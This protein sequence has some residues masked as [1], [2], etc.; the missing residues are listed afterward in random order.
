DN[1]A[2]RVFDK[3]ENVGT[4]WYLAAEM[5]AKLAHVSQL[6]PEFSLG[7]GRV[8]TQ[9]TRVCQHVLSRFRMHG[10]PTRKSYA[11][12]TSPQGGGGFYRALAI[13]AMLNSARPKTASF[14]T[15]VVLHRASVSR[16]RSQAS[17]NL[18]SFQREACILNDDV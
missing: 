10:S 4:Q 11:F 8:L 16:S 14:G 2:I 17:P 18:S 3:I 7:T 15:P 12:S 5:V 13:A 6:P 1:N 9:F